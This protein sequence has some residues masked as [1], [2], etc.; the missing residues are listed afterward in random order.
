MN[1]DWQN[2]QLELA[3]APVAEGEARSEGLEGTESLTAKDGNESLAEERL[4]EEV[5]NREN[6]KKALERVQGNKGSPGVD[7]MKVGELSGH[8]RKHWPK[9][10]EHL[11]NGRYRPQ[12]VLRKEIK[13]RDGGGMRQL[14]IPT[15]RDRFLQQALH[16][17]LQERWDASFSEHSYGFRPNRQAHQAVA[18]AQRYIREGYD[19]VVDIDLEKF[20]DRVN[21]DRLMSRVADRVKDK[22]VLKL[23]RAFLNAGVMEAG[24]VSPTNEGTPQGGPLS[25]LLSNLVLDELDRELEQRGHRFCRYADDCNIYVR[26][27]RAGHRVMKSISGFITNKLRLKVNKEKSAVD[28][29][30]RRKFLGFRLTNGM[31]SKRC[32]AALS[33]QRFRAQVRRLTSRRAGRS[34]DDIVERLNLYLAGWKGYYQFCQTP[35]VLRNMDSWIRR[36]LRQIIWVQWKTHRRRY[37]KLR[38]LG[39]STTLAGS[40]MVSTHG[41]WRISRSPALHIALSDAYFRSLGLVFLA[42]GPHA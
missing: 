7:G 3:F 19:W 24:L 1:D 35:S 15:V 30:G 42:S 37:R 2:D 8:L 5:L 39:V 16:Q 28:R 13:K 40:T 26:T 18:A 14:G 4:M 36:R 9:L 20:F 11:L 21:H 6:L 34:V 10:R 41:P 17:V 33:Q 32:I 22:R 25:P 31:S 38:R 12:P 23:I 27:E 29:P